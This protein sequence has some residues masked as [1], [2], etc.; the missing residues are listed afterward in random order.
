MVSELTL[1]SE[2]MATSRIFTTQS[3]SSSWELA[4]MSSTGPVRGEATGTKEK[5]NCLLP[6]P[7]DLTTT[8]ETAYT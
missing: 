6:F 3:F 1:A 7:S 8:G 4:A 2:V 5:T